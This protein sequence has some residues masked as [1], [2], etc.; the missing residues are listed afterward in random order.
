M[1][2]VK[3]SRGHAY[4]KGTFSNL[5]TQF[6]SYFAF[7]FYFGRNPLPASFRTISGYV[8]FLSR[9]IKPPSIRN[10]VSGVKMLHIFLGYEY[11]FAEDFHLQMV[12][13][14]IE[15][16]NP[17]VPQRAKPMTP[18]ILLIF[19]RYMD[20]DISLHRAVYSC[21][22]LLF[23]TLA[24]LGSFLPSSQ[25]DT[26]FLQRDC[27][28]FSKEGMLVTMLHTKTIQF[29]KRRLHIPLLSLESDLCP[30]QA[31]RRLLSSLGSNNFSSAFVFLDSGNIR[32]LTKAI[33]LQTFRQI[34]GVAGVEDHLAFT[35]H[36]FRQ[37]G[38]SW[39]FGAG[40]PGELI[41]ICGD[42]TSDAYKV[43][44][45]F[46]MTDKLLLAAQF[47]KNLC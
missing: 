32:R 16:L 9:S 20:H 26:Q 2:D 5:R 14:G 40:I 1:K 28:N 25:T 34:L 36:S 24:R 27:I 29:G 44:L 43:Y 15:R 47:S 41:Q 12:L 23:F 35:G 38:A 18:E 8:Q 3:R 19:H 46:T 4:A 10:Y 37:G 7:C 42:W 11:K 45:E 21:A 17:H 30:V 33:F 39:A 6:R 22:L 31:F 13:R